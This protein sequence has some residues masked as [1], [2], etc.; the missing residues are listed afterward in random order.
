MLIAM[1]L[2]ARY[3]GRGGESIRLA[4]YGAVV[5]VFAFAAVIMAGAFDSLTLFAAGTLLIGIG[6]GLFAVGTL[7]AAMLL[8]GTATAGLV[9]GTWGAVQATALGCA[10]FL[11]GALRDMTEALIQ[12]GMISQQLSGP[13]TPYGAVYHLEIIILFASLVALGPLV[14]RLGNDKD[15]PLTMKLA[16]F[17]S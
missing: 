17:P 3:L 12:G 7:T 11:G 2:S 5:G 4:A 6:N 8:A 13:A 10:V 1:A 14:R 9:I 16:D 15:Q